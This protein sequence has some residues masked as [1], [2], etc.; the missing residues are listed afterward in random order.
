MNLVVNFTFWKKNWGKF[1]GI[2]TKMTKISNKIHASPR[3]KILA[4][5]PTHQ[6]A[7]NVSQMHG[8]ICWKYSLYIRPVFTRTES[9]TESELELGRPRG[10]LLHPRFTKTLC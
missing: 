7:A 10:W 2:H 9:E 5:F 4:F 3:R 6:L 8:F 1:H